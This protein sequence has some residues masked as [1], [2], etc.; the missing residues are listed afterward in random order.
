MQ[1]GIVG[2]PN[3]TKTTI[4]NALTKS[5]AEELYHLG[6]QF[7]DEERSRVRGARNEPLALVRLLEESELRA[8]FVV[9][10][11]ATLTLRQQSVLLPD[12]TVDLVGW[13][14][15]SGGAVLAPQAHPIAYMDKAQLVDGLLRWHVGRFGFG[16]RELPIVRSHIERFVK[17]LPAEP[18]I[19][20]RGVLSVKYTNAVAGKTA[21]LHRALLAERELSWSQRDR[22]RREQRFCVPVRIAAPTVGD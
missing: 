12:S 10:A 8:R 1:I 2:L 21:A 7:V 5:Q 22:L 13:N 20:Q 6:Q 15:F 9:W 17:G 4:F 18:A 14:Y 16:E 11:A 3:S 19:H